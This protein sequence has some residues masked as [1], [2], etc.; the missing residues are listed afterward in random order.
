MTYVNTVN[1]GKYHNLQATGHL[2]LSFSLLLLPLTFFIQL[3]T[4]DADNFWTSANMNITVNV[5]SFTLSQVMNAHCYRATYAHQAANV[6]SQQI[7][8]CNSIFLLNL[9][10][11]VFQVV[12]K[13]KIQVHS[14]HRN[15][16][17]MYHNQ[18]GILKTVV[19]VS[20]THLRAHET[21]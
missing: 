12:K 9:Q 1:H 6:T 16:G 15:Y 14:W 17:L 2:P 19:S 4:T 10:Y 11:S 5:A 13:K 18:M 7:Q 21:A 3:S 20:Y 8:A